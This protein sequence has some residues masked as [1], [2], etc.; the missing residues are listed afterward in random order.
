MV[1]CCPCNREEF[2][3]RRLLKRPLNVCNW[4]LDVL[5]SDGGLWLTS[6]LFLCCCLRPMKSQSDP[7][8]S[9]F[10]RIAGKRRFDQ[11][12]HS[13]LRIESELFPVFARQTLV[14]EHLKSLGNEILRAYQ[15]MEQKAVGTSQFIIAVELC[16]ER[17]ASPLMR[18]L[19]RI[20][21]S[22]FDLNPLF[23]GNPIRDCS[24]FFESQHD[25][26]PA[27]ISAIG[28]TNLM[29]AHANNLFALAC[30]SS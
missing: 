18:T 19:A 21:N 5:R 13:E 10:F 11:L 12:G 29:P 17:R 26:P 8:M 7:L 30:A 3:D 15:M 20:C 1:P 28:V 2:E 24:F 23:F 16:E 27:L 22:F 25:L 14:S 4:A 9:T 6:C